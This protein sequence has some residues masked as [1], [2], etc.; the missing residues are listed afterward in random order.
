MVALRTVPPNRLANTHWRGF[1]AIQYGQSCLTMP[2]CIC[3]IWALKRISGDGLASDTLS[4]PFRLPEGV[5]AVSSLTS[6]SFSP[7]R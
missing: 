2:V 6:R 5:W 1:A 3:G 7:C 4:L